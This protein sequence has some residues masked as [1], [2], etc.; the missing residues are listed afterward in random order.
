MGK[1]MI[2]VSEEDSFSKLKTA[3]E[4]YEEILGYA[5]RTL[6]VQSVE[7][8]ADWDRFYSFDRYDSATHREPKIRRRTLPRDRFGRLEGAWLNESSDWLEDGETPKKFY[9]SLFL[10]ITGQ[11]PISLSDL[12]GSRVQVLQEDS[13]L[14]ITIFKGQNWKEVAR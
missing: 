10:K 7:I 14:W 5:G 9:A 13:G 12:D 1:G 3:P 6:R 8:E 2:E 4:L 11:E